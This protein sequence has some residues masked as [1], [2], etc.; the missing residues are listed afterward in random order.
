MDSHSSDAEA[1]AR[2][3]A[4]PSA[5]AVTRHDDGSVS[6]TINRTTSIADVNRTLGAMGNPGST[7]NTG[8]G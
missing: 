6:L 4:T 5:F 3:P 2:S 1:L 7:G 8:T